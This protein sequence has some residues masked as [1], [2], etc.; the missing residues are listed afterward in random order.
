MPQLVIVGQIVGDRLEA[1]DALEV[2]SPERHGG[3]GREIVHP[4]RP[5]DNHGRHQVCGDAERF[6]S[7]C[8][9]VAFRTKHAG[10]QPDA[11]IGQRTG[12]ARQIVRLHANI[13][14][15]HHQDRITRS[16]GQ[17]DERA[18]LAVGSH[19]RAF[20]NLHCREFGD[21]RS[22]RIA[23]SDAAQE[24]I[25]AF[26]PV[27]DRMASRNAESAPYTG[28][29]MLTPGAWP[30][31]LARALR[32]NDKTRHGGENLIRPDAAAKDFE[33][34]SALTAS[35]HTPPATSA[36]PIQRRESTCSLRITRARMVSITRLPA[37]AGTAKLKSATCT[38]AMKAKKTRPCTPRPGSGSSC[39]PAWPAR[40]AG[41]WA[42]NHGFLRGVSSRGF[43]ADRPSPWRPMMTAS[44]RQAFTSSLR[45]EGSR[46][47]PERLPP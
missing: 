2:C 47:P 10:D 29:R 41:R 30:W 15:V 40:G 23:G 35:N 45:Y 5:R 42:G 32:P 36:A 33:N 16:A 37:E 1:A 20:D 38:S 22:C 24:F 43:A 6:E 44:R 18:D 13:G 11:R 4:Q 26:E 31:R 12:H 21:E 17:I 19:G 14:V 3:A 39:A 34:H 27:C 7:G 8:W 46:G 9:G 28:F 25:L